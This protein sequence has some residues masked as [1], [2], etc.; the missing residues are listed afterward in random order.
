[1]E[2]GRCPLGFLKSVK[3]EDE[4]AADLT[5]DDDDEV[6]WRAFEFGGHLKMCEGSS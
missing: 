6:C 1:M 2:G 3:E 5:E 4:A